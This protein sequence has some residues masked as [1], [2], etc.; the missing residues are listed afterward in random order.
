MR[1]HMAGESLREMR[2]SVLRYRK[3][4]G[5]S[6]ERVR[7]RGGVTYTHIH[8]TDHDIRTHRHTHTHTHT[9]AHLLNPSSPPTLVVGRDGDVGQPAWVT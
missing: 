7:V 5:R 6:S 9:S 3:G 8:I 2:S 1:E 4:E